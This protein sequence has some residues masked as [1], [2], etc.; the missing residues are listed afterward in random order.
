MLTPKSVFMKKLILLISIVATVLGSSRIVYA[1]PGYINTIAGNGTS[2]YSG[3]G[4]PAL[5]AEMKQALG[6]IVVDNSGNVYFPDDDNYRIRK[7]SST[8]IITTVAGGGTSTA[9]GI[10]ATDAN[11]SLNAAGTIAMDATGNIYFSDGNRIRKI[12]MSTGIL[13]TIVGTGTG[14]YN[15]DG[16]PATAAELNYPVGICFDASGNL[17]I[18]DETNRRIR[19][20]NTSGII[21]TFAGTGTAG[22]SGDGGP[23]TAAELQSPDGV[24]AD[25]AGNLYV[26]DRYNYRIR[27]INTAG[28]ITTYAGS[29]TDEFC[30]DGGPATAACF[31]EPSNLR[32]DSY[33]NL[34]IADF[35]N[36]RVRIVNPSGIVNTFA[37]G[38]SSISSGIPATSASLTDVWNIG[39]DSYNNIYISDRTNYRI[40]RVGPGFPTVTAD[41]FSVVV[42]N[43][44]SGLNFEVVTNSY[45]AGQHVTT[46]FG[47][48]SSVDTM[49][50]EF[51]T[52]GVCSF[53]ESYYTGAY[54]IKHVLY[55][56]TTPVDSVSYT[57]SFV[58]CQN[59][60][61]KF[62]LDAN[63]NCIKDS[64]EIYLVQPV[65]TEVD[66]NG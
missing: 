38:G 57:Q 48:G 66:S 39:M 20:V 40:C 18:G 13:T 11:L 17:Y 54:S 50:T 46:Y 49:A 43:S 7:I 30:G 21:N 5:S 28:I 55:D 64:S 47:D 59:F 37:G 10:P 24:V 22:F 58:E 23:A 33:G 42:S 15:G 63:G 8:G 2:G 31:Y 51:G 4:G 16:G 27:K 60:T 14:G 1:Q 52:H 26:A 32:I 34:Y 29:G 9:D 53:F 35:H 56:G 3:D 12:T 44:C 45:S 65:L 19:I 61:V 36:G 6:G 41:S 62:Y 25:A